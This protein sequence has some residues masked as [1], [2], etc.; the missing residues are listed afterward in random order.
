MTLSDLRRKLYYWAFAYLGVFTFIGF[1]QPLPDPRAA[2]VMQWGSFIIW[3]VI[4]GFFLAPSIASFVSGLVKSFGF[5]QKSIFIVG[6][7]AL[8]LIE[9]AV[10]IFLNN[11]VSTSLS[12]SS[13]T[14]LTATRNYFELVTQKSVVVFIPMFIVWAYLLKNKHY[15]AEEAFLYF[16]LTGILAE[17]WFMPGPLIFIAGGFWMLV[18]GAMVYAPAVLLV[19]KK[20]KFDFSFRRAIFAIFLSFLAATPVA[21][22]VLV[23]TAKPV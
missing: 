1:S 7:T 15:S 2:I 10:A 11:N 20:E 4:M 17:F 13:G 16:G 21:F 18:Y 23:L 14:I 22:F 9:E 6:A 12:T 3:V 19:G 8:A 5:G